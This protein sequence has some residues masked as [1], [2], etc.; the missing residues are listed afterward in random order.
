[1]RHDKTF[2]QILDLC[3]GLNAKELTH[4]MK[5]IKEVRKRK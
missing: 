2:M 3:S 1:M 4:L 5:V